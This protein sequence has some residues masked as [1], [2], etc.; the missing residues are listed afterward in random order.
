MSK[1]RMRFV[2]WCKKDVNDERK[3][4]YTLKTYDGKVIK[5]TSDEPQPNSMLRRLQDAWIETIE[6]VNNE[7]FA[8]LYEE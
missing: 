2:T 5:F 6:L 1:R 4:N 8:T 7:W 3:I